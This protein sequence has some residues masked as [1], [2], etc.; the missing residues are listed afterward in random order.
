MAQAGQQQQ[1]QGLSGQGMQLTEQDVMQVCLGQTKEL[2]SSLNTY[3][4]E[5][6]NEQLR[7]DYMTALGDVYNQQKQ[8]FELMEQKGYYNVKNA[9]QQDISQAAS[10]FNSQQSM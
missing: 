9:T 1:S 3:I 10:K 2:A 8:L 5:A 6:N 7:R 4:L